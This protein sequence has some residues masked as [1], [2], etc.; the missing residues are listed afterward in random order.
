MR[1]C[2]YKR[3]DLDISVSETFSTAHFWIIPKEDRYCNPKTKLIREEYLN[4]T[5]NR[6]FG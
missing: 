4:E 5:N 1:R 6:D 2:L 3:I